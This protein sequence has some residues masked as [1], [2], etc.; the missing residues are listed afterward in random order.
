MKKSAMLCLLLAAVMLITGCFNTNSAEKRLD[1]EEASNT[2]TEVFY[3]AEQILNDLPNK[4]VVQDFWKI[5]GIMTSLSGNQKKFVSQLQEVQG[6]CEKNG[7]S[8]SKGDY[9]LHD[10]DTI[11]ITPAG[12]KEYIDGSYHDVLSIANDML[13]PALLEKYGDYVNGVKNLSKQDFTV[14]DD[15]FFDTLVKSEEDYNIIKEEWSNPYNKE[16]GSVKLEYFPNDRL[17]AITVPIIIS[18]DYMND[19]EFA[20]FY[21]NDVQIQ[22]E[23]ALQR[24]QDM[25][26]SFDT[27]LLGRDYL[28]LIYTENELLVLE[29][30]IKSLTTEDIRENDFDFQPT[31]YATVSLSVRYKETYAVISFSLNRVNLRI[32]G[33]NEINPFTAAYYTV[34]SGLFGEQHEQYS[35]E[36]MKEYINY[37]PDFRPE[38][39]AWSFDLDEHEKE[40]ESKAEKTYPL[41]HG[42]RFSDGELNRTVEIFT[43]EGE[44]GMFYKGK[45]KENDSII[46]EIWFSEESV[47]D[48]VYYYGID[49][50]GGTV[51]YNSNSGE[52]TVKCELNNCSGTYFEE[53]N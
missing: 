31:D 22:E 53:K 12:I 52:L 49:R 1:N 9:F 50:N 28:S 37:T 44:T 45:I 10:P 34:L 39:N 3:K 30:Y 27:F 14:T 25:I 46:C 8:L 35:A 15:T 38:I 32:I 26:E 33:A 16:L 48:G 2:T 18:S 5:Y 29:N 21:D 11:S 51:E 43:F 23:T 13:Y 40:Y 36:N 6:L 17:Q 4:N 24:Y 20:A 41:Y 47:T 7:T 42:Q 19:E